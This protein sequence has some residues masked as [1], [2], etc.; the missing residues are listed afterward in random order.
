MD[1]VL[2]MDLKGGFVVHGKKGDR[3]SY[4]PLTWGLSPTSDPEGYLRMMQPRFLYI[5]DLDRISGSGSH[6]PWILSCAREVECCYVDRGCRSPD[7][8]LSGERIVNIVGTETAGDL[9]CYRGG[10]LSI[11]IRHG[12]VVPGNQKPADVLRAAADLPFESCLVLNISAVGTGEG[13]SLPALCALRRVYRKKLF[14][15]GGI[16]DTGDLDRLASAGFDG[17]IVATAVHRG[18]IP[19]DLIRRGLWCS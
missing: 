10:M 19:H 3:E 11:D 1:L 13:L 7:D 14:Y 17:A 12:C 4:R 16:R 8:M 15:G 6:D 2:A 5:A 9:S 18:A